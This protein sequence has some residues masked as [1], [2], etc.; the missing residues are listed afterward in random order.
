MTLCA[1]RLVEHHRVADP[2]RYG[3][4]EFDEHGRAVGLHELTLEVI[5]EPAVRL[6]EALPRLAATLA[7][8]QAPAEPPRRRVPSHVQELMAALEETVAKLGKQ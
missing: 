1:R 6:P 5:V 2:Q 3:V 4:V 8:A 7:S